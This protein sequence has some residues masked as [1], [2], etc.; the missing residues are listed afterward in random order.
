MPNSGVA[1]DLKLRG[2]VERVAGTVEERENNELLYCEECDSVEIV[3]RDGYNLCLDCGLVKEE[4]SFSFDFPRAYTEKERKERGRYHTQSTTGPA[5]YV[6]DS[7]KGLSPAQRSKAWRLRKTQVHF[8][9]D[10]EA[11]R[12]RDVIQHCKSHC[13]QAGVDFH[14][15]RGNVMKLYHETNAKGIQ[16]N[17]SSREAF[18]AAFLVGAARQKGRWLTLKQAYQLFEGR[19]NETDKQG[20]LRRTW[21]MLG[22]KKV[23]DPQT[24]NCS[25]LSNIAYYCNE[26]G[27][28]VDIEAKAAEVVKT[29]VKKK[30]YGGN[31][32]NGLIAG[33]T[34]AVSTILPPK[35][36][37]KEMSELTGLS[38][39]TIRSRGKEVAIFL[40]SLPD[41]RYRPPL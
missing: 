9:S 30:A 7:N 36:T 33:A 35:C 16:M 3:E 23:I 14:S 2:K 27:L 19:R 41:E 24:F 20:E 13:E 6:G 25:P 38:E 10:N 34:Y 18:A 21:Y 5:T 40:N 22:Y 32:I 15:I 4:K 39:A 37:Q 26:L 1:S 31:D 11:R 12:L 17:I 8:G 29:M 28:S